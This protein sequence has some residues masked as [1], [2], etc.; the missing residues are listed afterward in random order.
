MQR[1]AKALGLPEDAFQGYLDARDT[2]RAPDEPAA[3]EVDPAN[4]DAVMLFLRCE[5]QWDIAIPPMG[6]AVIHLRMNY[7]ALDVAIRRAGFRGAQ[8][9]A[10]FADLQMMERAALEAFQR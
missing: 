2:L 5:T 9:R 1:Q 7:P 8:G 3:F 4:W 6:G 10:L